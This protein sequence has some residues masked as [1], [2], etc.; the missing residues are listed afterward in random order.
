MRTSFRRRKTENERH[1]AWERFG[2]KRNERHAAWERFSS[3][4]GPVEAPKG[5]RRI[6]ENKAPE[7]QNGK[8]EHPHAAW[9]CDCLKTYWKTKHG[10][11]KRTAQ[12]DAG[13]PHAAWERDFFSKNERRTA[14]EVLPL[15]PAHTSA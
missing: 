9:E 14:R 15:A 6:L 10:S 1:A 7:R 8:A 13:P 11:A 2:K 4:H 12:H 5:E 3:R